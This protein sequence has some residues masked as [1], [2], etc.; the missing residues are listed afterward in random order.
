MSRWGII[1]ITEDQDTRGPDGRS[2]SPTPRSCSA[3][4][5]ARRPTRTIRRRDGARR[6]RNNDYTPF[7]NAGRPEG[8]AH[9]HPARLLLRRR[10]PCPGRPEPRGGLNAAQRARSWPRRSPSCSSRAPIIVDPA[11]IPSIVRPGSGEE[12]PALEHVRR[13]RAAPGQGRRLHDRLQV[14]DEAGLQHVARDARRRGAREDA[15]GAARVESR[16]PARPAPSSTASRGSTSPTRWTSSATSARYEADRAKD[17]A[18]AGPTGIDAA[19]KA[20]K[21][22]ALLFPGSSGAGHRG[23]A[24]LPDRHRAV[25]HGAERPDVGPPFPAGF[26]AKPAPVRR[27]L[28]RHGVQRAAADRARLRVRAGDEEARAA[29]RPRKLTGAGPAGPPPGPVGAAV[30]VPT[31]PASRLIP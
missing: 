18:L 30:K 23:P 9:R 26:D 17:I 7:L 31:G 8:R 24:R 5:R 1:P 25:R 3:R 12:P 4:W 2:R 29:A 20:N 21:L 19:M 11:D 6:R 22:D 13:A 15:D 14:R 16:A 28:H 10:A 27:E